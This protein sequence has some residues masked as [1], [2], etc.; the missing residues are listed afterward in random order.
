MAGKNEEGRLAAEGRQSEADK[1]FEAFK[2]I[3]PGLLEAHG[4]KYAVLRHGELVQV[5]DTARDAMLFGSA[6][7]D[8]GMFSVQEITDQAVDLGF[9]SHAVRHVPI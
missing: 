4:G 9:Y 5:F 2:A 7:F 6:E 3:L 1:N 8:D